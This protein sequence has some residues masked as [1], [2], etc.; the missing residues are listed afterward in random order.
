MDT[1]GA[2][3]A[4]SKPGQ[5]VIEG[6][7]MDS[8]SCLRTAASF[9]VS[10]KGCGALPGRRYAGKIGGGEAVEEQV[11]HFVLAAGGLKP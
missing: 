5:R 11:R 10:G 6:P 1:V 7:A 3:I 2:G 9:P 8:V 4:Q